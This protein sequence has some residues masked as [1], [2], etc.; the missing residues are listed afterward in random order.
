[1]NK[2]DWLKLYAKASGKEERLAGCDLAVLLSAKEI[3]TS[4]RHRSCRDGFWI[5]RENSF[6]KLRAE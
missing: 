2:A 1:M 3:P 5:E 4:M 6:V